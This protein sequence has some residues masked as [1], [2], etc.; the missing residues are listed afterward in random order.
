MAYTDVIKAVND[1]VFETKRATLDDLVVFLGDNSEMIAQIQ[2]YKKTI[3]LDRVATKSGGRDTTK[4]KIK[5][6]P[7]LFNLFIRDAMIEL[8]V[9]QP[10]LNNKDRMRTAIAQWN[11]QK[12]S[13]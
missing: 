5:R 2:E 11:K 3:K 6:K 12:E 1:L 13:Q 4:P 8:K 7:S 9:S 10:E